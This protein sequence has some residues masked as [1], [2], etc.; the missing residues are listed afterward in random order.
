MTHLRDSQAFPEEC[1]LFE[2]AK[3]ASCVLAL[4]GVPQ[5][6]CYQKN[7]TENSK[8]KHHDSWR[9]VCISIIFH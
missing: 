7:M 1:L 2:C 6:Q 8:K 4:G 3:L 5:L 9:G